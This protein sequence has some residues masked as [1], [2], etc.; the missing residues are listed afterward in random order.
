MNVAIIA[1]AGQ[2]ARFGGNR[3][4]QFLELSGTPILFH[5]LRQFE[6]CDEIHEIIVVLPAEDTAGFL[7]MA[8]KYGLLKLGRVV[9]GGATRAESVLRGL[10]SVRPTT[11]DVVAIHDGVRPFVTVDEISRT[12]SAAK[13]HG[14]A[15]L[16]GRVRDTIKEMDGPLIVRTLDRARLRRALTPQCFRFELL[17]RA[18]ENVDITDPTVTDESVLMERLGATVVAIEGSSRNI[19]ITSYEDLAIGEAL[20][21][22][23]RG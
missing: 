7:A 19:K 20:L 10:Q 14:A 15:V 21:K 16:V 8:D 17:R 18:Y 4:K 12:V 2:G 22:M 1:A 5:T 6:Q 9:V 3:P 23:D 13:E 11:V